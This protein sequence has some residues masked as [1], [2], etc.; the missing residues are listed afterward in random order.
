MLERMPSL[1][2]LFFFKEKEIQFVL[3]KYLGDDSVAKSLF[4]GY[5]LLSVRFHMKRVPLWMKYICID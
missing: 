5:D 3:W 1:F 4:E 2:I